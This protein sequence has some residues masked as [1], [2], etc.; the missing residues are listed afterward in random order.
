[1]DE[2]QMRLNMIVAVN[3]TTK[4]LSDSEL[5]ALGRVALTDQDPH[6]KIFNYEVVKTL[7]GK[8]GKMHKETKDALVSVIERRIGSTTSLENRFYKCNDNVA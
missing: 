2:S 4:K 8:D 1:M 6:G 5:A 3:M 7:F